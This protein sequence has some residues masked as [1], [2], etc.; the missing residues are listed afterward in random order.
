[1]DKR[2]PHERDS[3]AQGEGT[4]AEDSG[5][6][7][8]LPGLAR[9]K[10][11]TPGFLKTRLS[12]RPVALDRPEALRTRLLGTQTVRVGAL[13]DQIPQTRPQ[14]RSTRKIGA[15]IAK[16]TG[17]GS[18][19][20]T[21]AKAEIMAHWQRVVGPTLAAFTRPES[22]TPAR[23]LEAGGTLTVIV[24][25]PALDLQHM[26]GPIVERINAHLGFNAVARLRLVQGHLAR[27][28]TAGRAGAA[29]KPRIRSLSP[30]ET[31]RLETLIATV[32]SPRL[33]ESLRRLGE[34]ALARLPQ[35]PKDAI[36]SDGRA[37]RSDQSDDQ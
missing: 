37:P 15:A 7:P 16:V 18:D 36:G 33:A 6:Y 1:V 31:T 19:R 34:S 22:F 17:R 11:V 8:A 35:E 30:E 29:A 14:A 2:P 26:Q 27:G 10:Q 3:M 25:G 12:E 9:K 28:Q 13:N 21:S 4:G 24:D 5:A 23:G 32:R 20:Q